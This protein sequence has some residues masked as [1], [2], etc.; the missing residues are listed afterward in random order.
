MDGPLE[1]KRWQDLAEQASTE[2]NPAR[3]MRLVEELLAEL[4]RVR[5]QK[6]GPTRGSV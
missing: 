1:R 2:D 6:R 3:L 5:E 4:S